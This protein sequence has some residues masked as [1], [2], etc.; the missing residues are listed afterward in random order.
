M[1]PADF[2]ETLV[3]EECY[4]VQ[5]C[6]A[7]KFGFCSAAGHINNNFHSRNYYSLQQNNSLDTSY[8]IFPLGDHAVTVQFADVIDE[9]INQ[10][11][12]QLAVQ[13][14]K[15]PIKSM[16]DII[17]AYAS[18]TI[19]YAPLK[20]KGI[21]DGCI[22]TYVMEQL[23]NRI[24]QT[25]DTDF[26]SPRKVHIPVCYDSS[27]GIDLEAMAA[28]K[29]MSIKALISFHTAITYHVY[30]IGFLPG[31]AYMGMVDEKIA[32]PRK[33]TPRQLVAAGSVGI[34]GLQ[35]GIYP[36]DSP[37]GWNIIGQTPLKMFD[38]K[39][40]QPCSLQPGDEVVF[41]P[42]SLEEFEKIKNQQ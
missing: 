41:E 7:T 1:L 6:D 4:R 20:I 33:A 14:Q 27:L 32:T 10:R 17:P 13:L 16:L 34:A 23:R 39:R 9:Q 22:S 25:A 8:T 5:V 3:V 19:V 29:N 2:N 42:I 30:M 31:F 40:A 38:K 28:E 36:L 11:V 35:T 21:G 18:L 15:E 24:E 37:G 12:L 26:I